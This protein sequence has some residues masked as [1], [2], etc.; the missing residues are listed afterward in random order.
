MTKQE[1]L[2]NLEKY[3]QGLRDRISS[4]NF[5]KR[6]N[7]AFLKLDLSKTEKAIDKLKLEVGGG[8]GVVAGKK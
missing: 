5:A 4:K 2:I 3:A 7:S 1:K 8:V 6:D